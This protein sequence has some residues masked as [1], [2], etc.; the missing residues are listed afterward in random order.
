MLPGFTE[1]AGQLNSFVESSG[2]IY[3]KRLFPLFW[4]EGSMRKAIELQ[5]FEGHW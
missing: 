2:Q 3:W 1:C 4:E 5:L